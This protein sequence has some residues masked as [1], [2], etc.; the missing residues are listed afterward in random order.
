MHLYKIDEAIVQQGSVRVTGLA[1][2]DGHR[3]QVVETSAPIQKKKS[4]Q[5][6]QEFL[7]G[8]VV[9]FDLPFEPSIPEDSWKMLK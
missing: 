7:R 1:V 4:I 6:V 2:P 5:E 3:V 8:S 9:R